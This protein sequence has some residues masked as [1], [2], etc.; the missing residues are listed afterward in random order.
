MVCPALCGLACRGHAQY[1]AFAPSSS[2][3]AVGSFAHNMPQV[4]MHTVSFSPTCF[5]CILLLKKRCAQIQPQLHYSKGPR[6]QPVS[7]PAIGCG[8]PNYSSLS[9]LHFP[10]FFS[11]ISS[12]FFSLPQWLALKYL[13]KVKSESRSVMSDSL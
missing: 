10:S 11:P 3:V 7:L 5:L 4:C 13:M 6:S 8:F 2:R 9:C 1:S 12:I